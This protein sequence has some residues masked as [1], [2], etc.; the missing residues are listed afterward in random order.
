MARVNR[1]PALVIGIVVAVVAVIL[2]VIFMISL[3][4][5]SKQDYKDALSKYND[6]SI[7]NSGVTIKTSSLQYSASSD[8]GFDSD[9]EA[10]KSAIKELEEANKEL[11][12]LKA[13][14][15]GEGKE[16][17]QA[18]NEKLGKY[19]THI[20]D[21]VTSLQSVKSV[22]STCED[23]Q[24]GA[25]SNIAAVTAGLQTCITALDTIGD[26]PDSDTKKFIAILKAEYTKLSTVTTQ[27]GGITDPYGKQYE[28]YSALRDQMRDITS[29][30]SKAASDYSSSTQRSADAVDPRTEANALRDFLQEKTR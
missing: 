5:V 10:V 7:A 8:S 22:L 24:K 29:T 18:F 15:T 12:K 23:A 28:Q 26:T 9:V 21:L 25:S 20:T 4:T 11:G 3:F 19:T 2:I 14:K 16:K 30:L 6:V 27:I 1:Q 13:V 17:Y